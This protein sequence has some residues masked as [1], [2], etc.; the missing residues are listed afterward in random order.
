MCVCVRERERER[1]LVCV[2]GLAV[3]SMELSRINLRDLGICFCFQI[4]NHARADGP[5]Q[6]EN[7]SVN[8]KGAIL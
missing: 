6:S 1:E 4:A 5:G 2:L 8:R 3:G 7:V